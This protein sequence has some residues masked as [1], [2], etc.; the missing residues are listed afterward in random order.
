MSFPNINRYREELKPLMNH[1]VFNNVDG[2]QNMVDNSQDHSTNIGAQAGT[3]TKNIGSNAGATNIGPGAGGVNSN[4]GPGAG[5][6]NSGHAAGSINYT[7]KAT[8]GG[9]Q[10]SYKHDDQYMHLPTWFLENE[11]QLSV[12][13]Y[14][15]HPSW[16]NNNTNSDQ[17]DG[18][19]GYTSGQGYLSY[20]YDQFSGPK[21]G[22]A[23]KSDQQDLVR[24]YTLEP[25]HGQGDSLVLWLPHDD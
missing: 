23:P 4:H 13:P 5:G 19:D 2:D 7:G 14:D 12:Q 24:F 20:D 3:K 16:F 8:K 9:D 18:F 21:Y 6:I 15:D 10:I 22:Q 11:S 1:F 25:T 17:T